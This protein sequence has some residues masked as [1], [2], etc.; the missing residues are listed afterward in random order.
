MSNSYKVFKREIVDISQLSENNKENIRIFLRE[1]K[2]AVDKEERPKKDTYDG[3]YCDDDHVPAV[4]KPK[5]LFG[6]WHLPTQHQLGQ[7]LP[8]F[9]FDSVC[10]SQDYSPK[11]S[12]GCRLEPSWRR[13]DNKFEDR[14]S[15]E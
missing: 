9:S 7:F 10:A 4:R 12:T 11:W 14:G 3:R 1:Y 15:L 5:K 6:E 2:L 13:N 8:S